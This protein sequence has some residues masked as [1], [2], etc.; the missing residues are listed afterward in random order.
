MLSDPKSNNYN[1]PAT[2]GPPDREMDYWA[3]LDRAGDLVLSI[4]ADG[5]F[6]HVNGNWLETLGYAPGEVVKL[7]VL[8]VI[9]PDEHAH[10][11]D[12]FRRLAGQE[13]T[14]RLKTVFINKNGE[15]VFVEG[16][17]GS[18]L[19]NGCPFSIDGIF[20]NISAHQQTEE[21]MLHHY[22]ILQTASAAKSEFL[23]NMS[24]EIRTPLNAILGMVN[25]AL[26]VDSPEL[27]LSYLNSIEK[28]GQALLELLTDILDLSRIEAGKLKL[29]QVPFRVQELVDSL[30][31]VFGSRAEEKGL[32]LVVP[33]GELSAALIGDP[34]RL[35]QVLFNL[36][37]NAIK[38]TAAGRVTVRVD[39][40]LP[41]PTQ[42]ELHIA[43]ADTGIGI[44]A[45]RLEHIFEAFTQAETS[46]TRQ[47]GGSGLGLNIAAQLVAMMD[48]RLWAESEE[49]R[50]SIFHFTV[51][52]E[53]PSSLPPA[54]I[55]PADPVAYIPTD[56][57]ILLVE[58]NDF[59][60]IV[61]GG[62]LER[63]GYA[64]S[65]VDNG[66]EALAALAEARFDLVLMDVQMPV[67]DGFATT[68]RI[69][70]GEERDGGRIPIIGL[71]AHAVT[72]DRERCLAAGMDSYLTKPIEPER[73]YAAIDEVLGA[74][75][76]D[77][78]RKP[79]EKGLDSSGLLARFA[80]DAALLGHTIDR[81]LQDDRQ[82]LDL[83]Q[84]AIDAADA[85]R[86]ERAAHNLKGPVGTLDLKEA[87][88]LVLQLE[89]IGRGG[90]ID[91][92][93]EL[94]ARLKD[95]I[96]RIEPDLAAFRERL[97]RRRGDQPYLGLIS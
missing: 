14:E 25:L 66:A 88:G 29:E 52:L 58:D 7:T 80:G 19:K 70:S 5:S 81:F 86:L 61:A 56:L 91:R 95:E 27:R 65:I 4:G 71:T 24:H 49:G 40:A 97:E 35:K 74:V 94:Y 6:L 22:E 69:R 83:L 89:G 63:R 3:L 51:R 1:K 9:A 44:P 84:N 48:G 31:D 54:A 93:A 13:Q 33:T 42:A 18:R 12:V 59:N 76:T 50:G 34:G 8:D 77:C 75:A 62:F 2:D 41:T 11:L 45:D 21:S 26:E 55:P 28:S 78:E 32:E 46:T 23:A 68:R 36:V 79:E 57:H 85:N 60:Q 96:E 87:Y 38:F 82:Y 92:A 67:L 30:P 64:V 90:S 15:L 73:L 20:R 39:C 37:S 16:S 47:F 53:I 17:V 10:C 43:V 72:G